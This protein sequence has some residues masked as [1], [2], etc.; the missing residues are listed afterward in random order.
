MQASATTPERQRRTFGA[1]WELFQRR[2]A[3]LALV[4]GAAGTATAIALLALLRALG[5]SEGLTPALPVA[6]ADILM[7]SPCPLV[8]ATVA[9]VAARLGA[10]QAMARLGASQVGG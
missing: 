3:L 9:L 5:G 4:A 1:R 2:Y 10:G 6:W 7:L 8:A